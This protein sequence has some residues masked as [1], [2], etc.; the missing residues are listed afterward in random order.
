MFSFAFCVSN[1]VKRKTSAFVG[2]FTRLSATR[3][4]RRRIVEQE[5]TD[6]PEFEESSQNS[7]RQKGEV[8]NVSY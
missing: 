7:R 6:F 4:I 8:K 2:Y 3:T 1:E 5:C